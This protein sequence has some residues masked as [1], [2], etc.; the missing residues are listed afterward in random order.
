MRGSS[1]SPRPAD[2]D[3]TMAVL[4]HLGTQT[5]VVAMPNCN[6]TDGSL[7]DFAVVG[8]AVRDVGA[9]LVVDAT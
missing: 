5:A 8:A 4:N 3:W 1:P 6:R 7:V 2:H 9:A